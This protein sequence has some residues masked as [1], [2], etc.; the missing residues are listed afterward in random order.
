MDAGKASSA[1]F[2]PSF[3]WA[4]SFSNFVLAAVVFSSS[5]FIADRSFIKEASLFSVSFNHID[6]KISIL[7]DK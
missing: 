2:K 1:F 6:K 7:L 3:N 5:A 4:F